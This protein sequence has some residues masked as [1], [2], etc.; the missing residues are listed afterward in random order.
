MAFLKKINWAVVALLAVAFFLR[1]YHFSE[2]LL[3]RLDQNRDYLIIKEAFEKG[4]GYLPLLGPK[5]GGPVELS[6]DSPGQ[7]E[8]L[9]LGPIYYYFQYLAAVLLGSPAPWVLAIPDLLFSV[10][11]LGMF[12]LLLRFKFSVR[13]SLLVVSLMAVSLPLVEYSRFA[14]NTNQVIFW[15][16]LLFYSLIKLHQKKERLFL[17]SLALSLAV[18]IQLH[19]IAFFVF[20]ALVLIFWLI[21]GFPRKVGWRLWLT[22]G[23]LF[24]FLCLP[25]LISD[26][27]N[28][29]ENFQ[30]LAATYFQEGANQSEGITFGK[31]VTKIFFRTGQMAGHSWSS[32]NDKEVKS[33]EIFSASVFF[34][35][36]FLVAAG[37]FAKKKH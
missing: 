21:F 30:R 14:W 1:S 27:F 7:G 8:A 20:P 25:M 16:V 35:G 24:L 37:L 23:T 15:Q 33:V 17:L 19:F 6:I 31:K 36:W 9:N 10:A 11:A 13:T 32:L 2:H 12:F 5:A 22:S 29:G 18:I 26:A 3:F 4:L 34:G 28:Q